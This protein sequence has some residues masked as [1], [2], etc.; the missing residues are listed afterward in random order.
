M[1][2]NKSLRIYSLMIL[3]T[4]ALVIGA[5]LIASAYIFTGFLGGGRS[6]IA[7]MQAFIVCFGLGAMF[8]LPA[9]ILFLMARNILRSSPK[10]SIGV[11]AIIISIPLW[12]YGI[13]GLALHLPF[14]L[15]TVIIIVYGL[16]VLGWG[17][18]VF[19]QTKR[20]IV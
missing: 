8:Y 2:H 9:A 12:V 18:C 5:S 1:Y 11:A 10:K 17:I 6:W 7:I 13:F 19:M 14:L 16:L 15:L 3:I 20:V 4:T